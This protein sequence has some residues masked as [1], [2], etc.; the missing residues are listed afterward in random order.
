MECH[1]C[2]KSDT[3]HHVDIID[4]R[5]E[6]S[7]RIDICSICIRVIEKIIGGEIYMS[8]SAGET[9]ERRKK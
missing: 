1:F 4:P 5:N 7:L 9:C 3:E 8:V 2:G 6:E